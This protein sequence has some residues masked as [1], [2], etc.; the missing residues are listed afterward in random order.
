AG[1]LY[2]YFLLKLSLR[3]G[4]IFLTVIISMAIASLHLFLDENHSWLPFYIYM[5]NYL[6]TFYLDI[7]FFNYAF[8]FLSIRN[9]KRLLPFLMGAGKFGGILSSVLIYYIFSKDI[10]RFGTLIWAANAILILLPLLLIRKSKISWYE[11]AASKGHELLPDY[12]LIERIIRKIKISI[13]SPIFSYTVLA[14]FIMSVANQIS[15]YYFANI[16]NACFKTKNELSSFLSLYT[17]SADFLTL[18]LQ[19]FIVS[20][21]IKYLG[22]QKSNLIYPASFFSFISLCIAFPGIVT[23]VLIRFYRKNMSTLIRAP[24]YNIIMASSPR[25]RMTEVKS[26]ISDIIN[27]LGMIASGGAI[28]LIYKKLSPVEGYIFSLGIGVLFILFS[29]LQ[30][31]AYLKTLKNRLS[32]DYTSREAREPELQDYE[33]LLSNPESINDNLEFIEAVFNEKPFLDFLSYLHPHFSR[34]SLKTRENIFNLLKTGKSDLSEKFIILG[35]QDA[36]PIIRCKAMSLLADSPYNIRKQMFENTRHDILESEKAAISILLSA[37]GRVGGTDINDYTNSKLTEIIKA[38]SN[39]GMEQLEL[40]ILLHVI[41]YRL[42]LGRLAELTAVAKDVQLLKIIIPHADLMNRSQA[43]RVLHSFKD[44]PIEYLVSFISFSKNLTETDKAI[45]LNHR[46]IDEEYM[47]NIFQFDEKTLSVILKRL[48]KDKNFKSKSNYLNYIISLDKKPVKEMIKFIGHEINIISDIKDLIHCTIDFIDEKPDEPR[49]NFIKLSFINIYLKEITE[50]HKK[51]IL[52]AIAIIS[53]LNIDHIHEANILLKDRDLDSYILE[54]IESESSIKNKQRLLSVF[55]DYKHEKRKDETADKPPDEKIREVIKNTMFFIPELSG[56]VASCLSGQIGDCR[57][58]GGADML[59]KDKN[60][61]VKDMISLLEKIIFL[62]KNKLFSELNMDDLLHIAKI[63]NEIDLPADRVIIKK[64][65]RGTQ[66]FIVISGEV[67]VFIG[68]RVLAGLGPGSCIGELS[69]I[70]EEPRS[71][72]VKTVK[73][74]TMLSI[75]RNDFLLTLKENPTIS[76]NIMQ[77][78]TD[79]LRGYIK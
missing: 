1:L 36:E 63:T 22:V 6:F 27:P 16:F 54:F 15:E 44:A 62:K 64:G 14:V 19:L 30:N 67:E 31:R 53:G 11:K 57:C 60:E 52:K 33:N 38:V 23:G 72:N 28:L 42:L 59:K 4:Y 78:I 34:L 13:S 12:R 37:E 29:I 9:S 5:G 21:I 70:D 69:I 2:N 39:G 17:F 73:K 26:F 79:R 58:F 61:G 56:F 71:A 65:D 50:L 32:F 45:L 40:I 41:P 20:R 43:R 68:D 77:V 24:I 35:L 74:T 8:Q 66:L 48:F 7:H 75:N 76:I 25:D 47:K 49:M 51:L 10:E 18:I 55:D 46:E 3:N